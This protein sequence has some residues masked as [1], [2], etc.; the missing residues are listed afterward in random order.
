M[1]LTTTASTHKWTDVLLQG[2]AKSR[3]FEIGCHIRVALTFYMH[4]GSTA[5]EAIVKF[6]SDWKSLSR[7]FETSLDLR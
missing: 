2:L 5:A 4:L 7:G 3:S 1:A 6:Q